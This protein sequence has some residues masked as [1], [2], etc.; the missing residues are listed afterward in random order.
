VSRG[1]SEVVDFEVE[2]GGAEV[3]GL[4]DDGDALAVERERD[5]NSLL[6]GGTDLKGAYAETGA[7]RASGLAA[8]EDETSGGTG[9]KDSVRNVGEGFGDALAGVGGRKAHRLAD[10]LDAANL[11]GRCG[12][13]DEDVP[14]AREGVGCVGGDSGGVDATG[15]AV[16][17][18]DA[19]GAKALFGGEIVLRAGGGSR[20]AGDDERGLRALR[21]RGVEVALG[22]VAEE[23][24]GDLT[25]QGGTARGEGPVGGCA[26]DG[27][28]VGLIDSVGD[29]TG[30]AFE[31][32]AVE[33]FAQGGGAKA[34]DGERDGDDGAA[35]LVCEPADEIRVGHGVEGVVA[36][37]GVGEELIAD[38]VETHA[39]GA[40]EGGVGGT[41]DGGGEVEGVEAGVDHGTDIAFG[42]GV[43]GRADFEV[44]LGEAGIAK[45]AQ[46]A[47]N[48]AVGGVRIDRTAVRG[49]GA[50]VEAGSKIGEGSRVGGSEEEEGADSFGGE[51][52]GG[53]GGA[54]EVVGDDAKLHGGLLC[55]RGRG[56]KA[57]DHS[58][59]AGLRHKG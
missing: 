19:E 58:M 18:G 54:G 28:Y 8:C 44:D 39:G 14:G 25:E 59:K 45:E 29:E 4:E 37:G 2:V 34:D 38:E 23:E 43:E 46:D 40:T 20:A 9:L 26:G 32:G 50:G 22:P 31:N 33:V 51:H 49:D 57:R 13:A 48:V 6:D 15:E 42:G 21:E 5:G 3:P 55:R 36:E 12:G 52:G 53:V 16:F 47:G 1:A 11:V 41:D 17:T 10:V 35:G 24:V 7:D 27:C 30:G 56:A